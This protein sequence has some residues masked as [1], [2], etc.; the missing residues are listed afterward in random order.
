MQLLI[1]SRRKSQEFFAPFF[2]VLY[3]IAYQSV[4]I[5]RKPLFSKKFL[6]TRLGWLFLRISFALVN[7]YLY[8]EHKQLSSHTKIKYEK[9][10]H[11]FAPCY[12]FQFFF[13]HFK[14]QTTRKT[15]DELGVIAQ[16]K[17]N[18]IKCLNIQITTTRI[19]SSFRP[20]SHIAG[21]YPLRWLG[22]TLQFQYNLEL[23]HSYFLVFSL[24]FVLMIKVYNNSIV[25]PSVFYFLKTII[26]SEKMKL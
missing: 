17:L 26:F 10:R 7:I 23:K 25:R 18:Q 5:P 14:S 3:M 1:V 2:F 16:H 24:T 9:M 19:L 20:T 4:L 11:R 12:F 22:K 13:G 21:L 15:D 6:V 8:M